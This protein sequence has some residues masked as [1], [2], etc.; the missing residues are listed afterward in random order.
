MSTSMD[1]MQCLRTRVPLTL[2]IDLLDERGPNSARILREDS[3]DPGWLPTTTLW[4]S[5]SSSAR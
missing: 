5:S 1:V 2:L 4:S 3:Y